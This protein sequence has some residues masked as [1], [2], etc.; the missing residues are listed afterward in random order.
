[1]EKSLLIFLL[2]SAW[3]L[4]D[5]A[6]AQAVDPG[7]RTVGVPGLREILPGANATE[8]QLFRSGFNGFGQ[9]GELTLGMGPRFNMMMCFNCHAFPV[10]GGTTEPGLNPQAFPPTD[11]NVVPS[12]IRPDGPILEARFK[13]KPDGSPDGS[14]HPLFVISGRVD[15]SGNAS[16]CNIVQPDFETEIARGN[17]SLRTV[18]PVLGA[19]LVEQIAESTILSNIAADASRKAALGI[20]GRVNR[21]P[22]DDRIGRFGWKAQ[23]V[24]LQLFSAEALAVEQGQTNM[25]FPNESDETPECQ[26][27]PTP[28]LVPA[29]SGE[30]VVTLATN[31]MK[32]L[33]PSLPHATVPGGADSITRGRAAFATVGCATCHTPTM[34]T[35]SG[36]DFPVLANKDVNL[37]SDLALHNMGPGL[38]DDIAQ[39]LAKGDEFRTAPLW[40][41]G[42]RAFFLH[43]GRTTNLIEAIR[44]HRSAGNS[45]YGPSE[46]N[47]VIANYDALSAAEQQDLLNFLRSL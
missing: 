25:F 24:S 27:S 15:P 28:N 43:D 42:T 41:V 1:M 22:N 30:D 17:V 34:R 12:F 26:F 14:V 19:G 10:G 44:A 40:G 21:G 8:Q 13:R 38:A 6:S 39:G 16:N 29:I 45:S 46:A 2:A 20:S 32:F 7:I 33:A 18:T 35:R 3:L 5:P 4:A 37:Y 23:N 11:R 31:F 36:T 9:G 47:A